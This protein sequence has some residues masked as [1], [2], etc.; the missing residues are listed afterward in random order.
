MPKLPKSKPKLPAWPYR[1]L[2]IRVGLIVVLLA[3]SLGVYKLISGVLEAKPKLATGSHQSGAATSVKPPFTPVAPKDKPELAQG[4]SDKTAYDGNRD[5]Y[6][7][8]DS[9][10]G[11]SLTVSQQVRPP[12]F[13]SA[14]QAVS[15]VAKSAGAREPIQFKDGTAYLSTD[16]KTGAQTI[17]ASVKELLIF[18][19]SPYRHSAQDW[20]AYL[21]S[22]Q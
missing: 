10:L 17:I 1:R 6:S 2:A 5:V 21:D 20:Q 7:Y 14:Q 9:L 16:A 12:N 19:Q 15:Q 22:L 8:T 3:A 13:A 11:T 4:G 18:I